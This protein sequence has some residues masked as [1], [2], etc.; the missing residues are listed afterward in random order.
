MN[1]FEIIT[2]AVTGIGVVLAFGPFRLSGAFDGAGRG[3]SWFAHNE[4]LPL[5]A[6]PSEDAVD[7]PIPVRPLRSR[8]R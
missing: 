3:T 1:P 8:A 4:D 2:F 5:D 7:A 6:R